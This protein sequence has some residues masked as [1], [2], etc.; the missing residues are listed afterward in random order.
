LIK[1][2]LP[3]FSFF[4]QKKHYG[5][6]FLFGKE[7]VWLASLATSVKAK[8]T[9]HKKVKVLIAILSVYHKL[10]FWIQFWSNDN[11]EKIPPFPPLE[12]EGRGDLT[13]NKG[14]VYLAPSFLPL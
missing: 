5:I 13:F 4:D 2:F 10:W 1:L 8:V 3:N 7:K 6:I 9:A 11:P 12:K 14:G